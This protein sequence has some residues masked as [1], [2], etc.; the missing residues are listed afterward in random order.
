MG[1]WNGSPCLCGEI[2]LKKLEREIGRRVREAMRFCFQAFACEGD[3]SRLTGDGVGISEHVTNPVL[4]AELAPVRLI[5]GGSRRTGQ[6]HGLI[7]GFGENFMHSMSMLELLFPCKRKR[8]S[9]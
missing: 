3:G 6:Q 7:L 8:E 1:A 2:L 4:V 9:T 5:I